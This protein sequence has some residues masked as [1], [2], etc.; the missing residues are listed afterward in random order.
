MNTASIN[1]PNNL[2]FLRRKKNLSQTEFATKLICVETKRYAK[3]EEKRSQPDVDILVD[4]A[5]I[6]E[7]SVDELLTKDLSQELSLSTIG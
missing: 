6:H 2:I 4:I 7:I 1:L 3:W 5:K